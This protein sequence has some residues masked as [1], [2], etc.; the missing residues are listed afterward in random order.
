MKA[1]YIPNI[2]SFLRLLM[3]PLF[4]VIYFSGLEW[5][6]VL[7]LAVFILAGIT[8]IADGYLARKNGWVT[9]LGKIIDPLADKLMQ[10][11]VL[12]CLLVAEVIP[13]W[14]AALCI[15]KE[16]M[17]GIGALVIFRSRK[18]VVVSAWCGKMAVVIFYIAV[19]L[20]ILFPQMFDWARLTLCI[21][22]VAAALFAISKYYFDYFRGSRSASAEEQG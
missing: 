16:I 13:W 10:V 6:Y 19:I 15:L 17:M 11:T 18:V 22:T 4:A 3:V 7:A 12:I 20:L 8:D 9:T 5:K 21:V 2:L 1:R 14:F